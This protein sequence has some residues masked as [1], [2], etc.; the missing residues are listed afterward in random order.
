MPRYKLTIEYDGT[1][2]AGWQRQDNA[3]SVQQ[4]L[5]TAFRG[6][7]QEEVSL[8][9]SGRTDAGVHARGQVA[10]IDLS[11]PREPFSII[12]GIHHHLGRAPI[13][14]VSA[15]LVSDEFHARFDALSRRYL[16]R[17]FNRTAQPVLE[18]K[19]V[20]HVYHAMEL[21]KMREAAKILVG[22]HDFT[23]FRATSCQSKSPVKTLDSLEVEQ[24]GD[25]FH[26]HAEAK[27]FLHNQ[28]RNIAG[29]LAHVGTGKWS[30]QDVQDALD[31][32]DRKAGPVKAPAHGLYFMK[33]SY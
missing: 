29:A 14:I 20:W 30:V 22:K 5:E 28:V 24:V 31:A 15:E 27:S 33:V 16:Y 1:P 21:E 13:S 11:Q 18:A 32:K 17:I 7:T 25:E 6:Y 9:C 23:S 26:I 12:Q 4:T 10:H 8:T 3:N 19:R 2:Y